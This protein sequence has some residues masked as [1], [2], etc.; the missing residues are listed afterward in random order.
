MMI[1]RPE[2]LFRTKAPSRVVTASASRLTDGRSAELLAAAEEDEAVLP[3][4]AIEEATEIPDACRR[5]P[6]ALTDAA[7]RDRQR[8]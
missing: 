7:R 5:P 4:R 1:K 6:D 8:P 2:G 3:K